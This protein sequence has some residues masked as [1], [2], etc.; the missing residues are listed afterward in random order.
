MTSE[1]LNVELFDASPQTQLDDVVIKPLDS[2]G[3]Y[4]WV[5]KMQIN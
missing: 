3:E 2:Q 1:T 4:D 5:D